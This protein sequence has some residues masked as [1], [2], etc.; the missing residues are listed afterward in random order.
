MSK[1]KKKIESND[2]DNKNKVIKKSTYS[3]KK[4]SKKNYKQWYCICS[5]DI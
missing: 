5:V 2:S 3:K 1:E 4:K